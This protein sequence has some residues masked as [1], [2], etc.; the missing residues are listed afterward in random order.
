MPGPD[1]RL[2]DS[3]DDREAHLPENERT[4]SAPFETAY[5]THTPPVS[6]SLPLKTKAKK[7]L[8]PPIAPSASRRMRDAAVQCF[9]TSS[10]PRNTGANPSQKSSRGMSNILQAG[11]SGQIERSLAR[12][13]RE[14]GS[15]GFERQLSGFGTQSSLGGGSGRP[16]MSDT[17]RRMAQGAQNSPTLFHDSYTKV[18]WSEERPTTLILSR[19]DTSEIRP[20]PNLDNYSASPPYQKAPASPPTYSAEE[21]VRLET[22]KT[23]LSKENVQKL[24]MANLEAHLS[25]R[26]PSPEL[27][28]FSTPI[29]RRP[30]DAFSSSS[31]LTS[32][33]SLHVDAE[34][35][36]KNDLFDMISIGSS[37]SSLTDS[38]DDFPSSKAI[39]EKV[40][41]YPPSHHPEKKLSNRSVPPI[42]RDFE[43]YLEIPIRPRYACSPDAHACPLP[44]LPFPAEQ[45]GIRPL[46]SLV[47]VDKKRSESV[48][49]PS[50]KRKTTHPAREL[51]P[52]RD[53]AREMLK[54]GKKQ[55]E[56]KLR[57]LK[58]ELRGLKGWKMGQPEAQVG[59]GV[60]VRTG[61]WG[62]RWGRTK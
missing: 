49:Y 54:K 5:P 17:L 57:D 9:P 45:L 26:A 58:M 52:S 15:R 7:M 31:K 53:L 38:D 28:A 27:G 14:G 55:K 2:L 1:V 46:P 13:S 23:L 60:L 24:T 44:P 29:S 40:A 3:W 21:E 42:E 4:K 22:D 50:K 41:H 16:E 30:Y 39:L 25:H 11:Y 10:Q 6:T 33:S 8:P 48:N 18:T 19:N 43:F 61:N 20:T 62:E 47:D 51:L 34:E 37:L 56:K 12:D 32:L 59:R 35:E 36:F